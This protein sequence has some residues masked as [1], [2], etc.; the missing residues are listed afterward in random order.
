MLVA[1]AHP[2]IVRFS[3]PP[4]VLRASLVS[5][6]G[7]YPPVEAA[8]RRG[9]AVSVAPGLSA[10][11]AAPEALRASPGPAAPAGGAAQ[12]RSGGTRAAVQRPIYFLHEVKDGDTLLGIARR[13]GIDSRYISWNNIDIVPDED[14]LQPGDHLRIP[15]VDGI[16]HDVRLGET[17]IEIAEAYE[18][19]ASE[20]VDFPANAISDPDTLIEGATL[21]VVGGRLPA[22]RVAAAL[23]APTAA[24][25][26]APAPPT[27]PVF[28]W[29]LR[30]VITSYFGP[31]H[32][33]GIDI[34]A[35][36]GTPIQAA[37][38]GQ[39][40]FAGGVE[41]CS[42]GYYVEIRHGERFSTLYAHLGANGVHV[43]LGDRVEAGQIIGF[44]GW[45]GR[46]TGPHLHFEIRR[47][48]VPQ[49]PLARLP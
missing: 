42:Y 37:A 8:G 45:S 5:V 48:D 38:G 40:V 16:L 32:P 44:T 3:P 26:A 15:S 18:A 21:L 14:L 10:G 31:V 1:G 46:M 20:I 24:A 29:P 17:L 9:A 33:L 43:R 11:G 39:V 41:C 23:P 49:N 34:S 30:G 25:A 47:D 35:P 12:D 36:I 27:G 2:D 13:Y 7:A 19:E 22:A 4:P 28:S 6:P